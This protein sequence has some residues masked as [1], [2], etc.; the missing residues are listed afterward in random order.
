M[1][2]EAVAFDA[3]RLCEDIVRLQ[4]ARARDRGVELR[5]EANATSVRVLGDPLRLRQILVSLVANAIKFTER[6]E[7]VLVLDAARPEGD[8]IRVRISVRDSGTGIP[9]AQPSRSFQHFTQADSFSTRKHGGTGL[10][11]AICRQLVEGSGSRARKVGAAFTVEVALVLMDCMMP[12]VDG[13]EATAEI[14][15]RQQG[16]PPTPVLAMAANA[17]QGDRDRCFQAGMDDYLSKPAGREALE[18]VLSR[19]LSRTEAT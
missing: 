15:R 9:G 18:R 4:G 7:V 6:Y 13:Y 3:A 12:G 1:T 19:W 16:Q 10:C 5:L 2:V 8:A 14:R 17:M 11:L